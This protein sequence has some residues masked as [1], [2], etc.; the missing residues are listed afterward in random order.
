MWDNNTDLVNSFNE[1]LVDMAEFVNEG[2]TGITHGLLQIQFSVLTEP[3][4]FN[5]NFNFF[6]WTKCQKNRQNV[7]RWKIVTTLSEQISTRL[8]RIDLNILM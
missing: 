6:S 1:G 2:Y 8:A 7:F 5:Q 4:L 3:F